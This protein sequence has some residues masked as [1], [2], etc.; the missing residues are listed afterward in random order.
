MSQL[1]GIDHIAIAVHNLKESLAVFETALGIKL[2]GTE[3]LTPRG[4][5]TAFLQAGTTRIELVAP[6]TE[7]SEVSGF[8]EK[9]GEGLHHLCLRVEEL[10]GAL[11]RLSEKGFRLID[12]QPRPGAH[13]TEV[14]FVHP[15][16]THGVLIELV[17]KGG[18]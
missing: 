12:A 11:A 3:T 6:I 14:A 1:L 10:R 9:R 2:L 8:L 7:T 17:G 18:S 4:L 16:S 15:K 13:G 5:E